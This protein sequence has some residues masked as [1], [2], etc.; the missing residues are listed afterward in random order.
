MRKEVHWSSHLFYYVSDL[1]VSKGKLF[2]SIVFNVEIYSIREFVELSFVQA[3]A[4]LAFYKCLNR[5]SYGIS[6]SS[7][8]DLCSTNPL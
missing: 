2:K 1:P 4:K 3:V 6:R 7:S 8:V 5:L